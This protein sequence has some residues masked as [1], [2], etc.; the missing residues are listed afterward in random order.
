M[1]YSADDDK[2]IKAAVKVGKISG[3][4]VRMWQYA[5]VADRAGTRRTLAELPAGW[6]GKDPEHEARVV[7]AAAGHE[8][9]LRGGGTNPPPAPPARVDDMG[10]PLP[11]VPRPILVKKGVNPADY[12]P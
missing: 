5:M 1:A 2:I 9:T 8:P 7:A 4:Y 3:D 6:M 10:F 12:T 11:D